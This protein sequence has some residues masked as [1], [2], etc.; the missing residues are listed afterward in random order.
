[1][2]A[3]SDPEQL[4]WEISAFVDP[5][6]HGDEALHG[7]LVSDVGVVQAGVQHDDGEG[8][9]VA[10]VCKGDY[11]ERRSGACTN[12]W[13]VGFYFFQRQNFTVQHTHTNFQ[14]FIHYKSKQDLIY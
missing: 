4:L 11:G 3:V 12:I 14:I 6:V 13:N 1:M 7:R 5:S 9:D 10:G 8:Q 2:G